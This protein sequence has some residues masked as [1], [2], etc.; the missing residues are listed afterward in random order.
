MVMEDMLRKKENCG[1]TCRSATLKLATAILLTILLS[2]SVNAVQ[3]N[4]FQGQSEDGSWSAGQTKG[5]AEGDCVPY[6]IKIS[7]TDVSGIIR[8]E[9][10]MY[11]SGAASGGPGFIGLENLALKDLTTEETLTCIACV[12][13]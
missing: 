1:Y 9:T 3:V 4:L 8:I 5:W 13:G 7:E 2:S 6:R 11:K 10:A 12:F